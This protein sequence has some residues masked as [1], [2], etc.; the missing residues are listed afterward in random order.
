MKA[1][2]PDFY[3]GAALEPVDLPFRDAFIAELWEQLRIQHIVLSAPRRT[4]KTSVLEHLAERP[5]GGF[6]PI[7]IFVQDISHPADFILLLLDLF[8]E[9][10]PKLFSD[11]FRS[12]GKRIGK[13]LERIAEVELQGF[14]IALRERDPDWRSHWKAYGD[15]FFTEVRK[16]PHPV[17]VLV[18]E[19][20]DMILN[21]KRAHPDLVRPFL[22]WFRGHRLAPNPRQD[23]V[24]W[25][26]CGS[27][28][29]SSTL[30]S[31]G[32]LD[33]VND[34]QDV[35]LPVLT[36]E[37]VKQFVRTMLAGRGVVFSEQ[38]PVR[39]AAELG[40]PIPLFMQMATQELYRTWKRTGKKLNARDVT[41]VFSALIISSGARDKLQHFH[42]RIAQYY[43]S[44]LDAAAYALLAQLSLC[45]EGLS[46]PALWNAFAQVLHEAGF[47]APPDAR[48]QRFNQ[49]LRDLE[50]DFYVAEIAPGLFDFASGLLKQ[51]WKKYYA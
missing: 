25:L 34:L 8:H 41:E 12:G 35:P 2:I 30:D 19:F 5:Q 16:N 42:S 23:R 26:I 40:R 24:R 6:V 17:L 20:P 48:K 44:P 38:V 28:N 43:Q 37:E 36:P 11:L 13:A 33:A 49:L 45:P 32:C 10:Q 14:K 22:T 51:W 9:R 7:Q 3:T 15:E 21:M 18:D 47:N 1:A 27:L 39:V 29:L 4:G 46:R 50:N 31:L